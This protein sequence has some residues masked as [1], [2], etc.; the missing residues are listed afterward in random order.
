MTLESQSHGTGCHQCPSLPRPFSCLL[1]QCPAQ[2]I[3]PVLSH[4]PL[5]ASVPFTSLSLSLAQSP[6]PL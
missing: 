1:P 2:S 5:P 6:P 3:S 4:P